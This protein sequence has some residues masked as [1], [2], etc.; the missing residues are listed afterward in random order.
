MS[1]GR[2]GDGDRPRAQRGCSQRQRDLQEDRRRRHRSIAQAPCRRASP[3]PPPAGSAPPGY[4]WLG[5]GLTQMTPA[6]A[7]LAL[8]THAQEGSKFTQLPTSPSTRVPH[9]AP[10]D[11]PLGEPE[12]GPEDHPTGPVSP[13]TAPVRTP[14]TRSTQSAVLRLTPEW[15]LRVA[16][17]TSNGSGVRTLKMERDTLGLQQPA[18]EVAQ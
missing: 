5:D 12:D 4:P 18:Q 1:A 6:E 2:A 14:A 3:A 17:S 15:P 7:S 16:A 9:L 11:R 8:Y 13:G 10:P